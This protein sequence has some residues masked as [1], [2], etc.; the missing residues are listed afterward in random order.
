MKETM[1][2]SS[3]RE[4]RK[5]TITIGEKVQ[6]F[7]EYNDGTVTIEGKNG[8]LTSAQLEAGIKKAQASGYKVEIVS[9]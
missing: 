3:L 9:A 7:V 8:S 1:F 5:V 4:T 2:A 6:S